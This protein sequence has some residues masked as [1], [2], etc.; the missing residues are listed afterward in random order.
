MIERRIKEHGD[1]TV[2]LKDEG[3]SPEAALPTSLPSR[4]YVCLGGEELTH[5][6]IGQQ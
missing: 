2:R 6:G 4:P 1:A 3:K 5:T